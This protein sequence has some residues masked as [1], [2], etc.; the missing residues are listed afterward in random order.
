MSR[1]SLAR[2]E[3][4]FV[5]GRSE[6]R[7]AKVLFLSMLTMSTG[8][9]AIV[10][11]LLDLPPE[12]WD[13]AARR[14][15]L[16]HAYQR[17]QLLAARI[18]HDDFPRLRQEHGT[19]SVLHEA[20]IRLFRALEQVHPKTTREFFLLAGQH[21]RW[22]LLDMARKPRPVSLEPDADVPQEPGAA[23]NPANELLRRE[24]HE[25]IER[26]APKEREIVHCLIYLGLTQAETARLLEM[27]PKQVSR[28]WL[29]TRL[30]LAKWLSR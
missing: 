7:R 26:L 13:A 10:Q 15:L 27:H 18:F 4:A 2:L 30:S 8:S 12:R 5:S 9:T 3:M 19:G 21:L 14:E 28:L 29:Q 25:Q 11:Q 24:L 6:F 23:D 1:R 16:A 22:V 17:L 20:V